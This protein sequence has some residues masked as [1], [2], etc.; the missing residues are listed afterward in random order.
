M[1]REGGG[2]GIKLSNHVISVCSIMNKLSWKIIY[3]NILIIK[4]IYFNIN[5]RLEKL[6]KWSYGII[7]FANILNINNLK[8]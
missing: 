4:L 2:K 1:G 8:I 5:D 3:N 7:K 6:E